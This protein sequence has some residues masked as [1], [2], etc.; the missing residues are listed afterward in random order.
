MIRNEVRVFGGRKMACVPSL[1]REMAGS[2]RISVKMVLPVVLWE[3]DPAEPG[4]P[5]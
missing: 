3:D 2:V 5:G 4:M 1:E